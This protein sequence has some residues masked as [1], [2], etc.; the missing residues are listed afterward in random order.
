[1]KPDIR[2]TNT[3]NFGI[4]LLRIVSMLYV[5]ISHVIGQGAATREMTWG[6]AQYTVSVA[7]GS[8]ALCAVNVFGIISGYVGYSDQEKP[9]HYENYLMMWLQVVFYGVLVST[10]F[11]I[12]NSEIVS[13]R[14]FLM[15]FFPVTNNLYWYFTAY[16]GL[17]FLIP[18]INAGIRKCSDHTLLGIFFAILV[19]FSLFDSS[20][21]V[22]SLHNG[23][24]FSWLFLLYILGA[25]LKKTQF[26]AAFSP[27]IL[28]LGILLCCTVSFFLATHWFEKDFL[29]LHFT[30]S[31]AESLTFFT[32]VCVAICHV[33]LFSKL[34]L[35]AA[36]KAII[37]FAAPGAFA[38]YLLNNQMFTWEYIMAGRFAYLGQLS[39]FRV[40]S[41]ILLFSI[42]FVAVSVIIDWIRRK[43]FS[44]LHIKEL[45]SFCI[46]KFQQIACKLTLP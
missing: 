19:I 42:T 29:F 40:L 5:V 22:F 36:S 46:R 39:V 41:D 38:V 37:H 15:M 1:M 35:G 25:I 14:Q 31:Q 16:T 43:L 33:L 26:G 28:V 24:S 7:L 44:F 12:L 3:R 34:K 8:L 2:T 32:H 21:D 9:F 13:F 23:Y 4:D 11:E 27:F 10:F 20:A 18:F 6:S 45:L 30:S 17:F